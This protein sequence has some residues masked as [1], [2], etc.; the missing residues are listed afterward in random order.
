MKK[1]YSLLVVLCLGLVPIQGQ[2]VDLDRMLGTSAED[3]QRIDDAIAVSDAVRKAGN[4]I[5][6]ISDLFTDGKV[7]LPVG[8]K[9]SSDSPYEL[10]IRKIAQD[11]KTEKMVISATCA[12][13]FKDTGDPIAFEGE[14]VIE[15]NNGLGT[16]GKLSLITPVRRNIGKQSTLV[17]REGTSVSFNCEGIEEFDAKMTWVVT[18]DK[19]IPVDA[20]GNPTN[21][22]LQVPFEMQFSNFDSYVVSL[23][24]NQSFAIKSL[25]QF[26]N[27]TNG[28]FTVD[29]EL[30]EAGD[31]QI[32]LYEVASGMC[33][34]RR[35]ETGSD[36]YHLSY[37]LPHLSKGVY[38]L[39]VTVGSERRQVGM[40][41]ES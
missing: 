18:S 26:P 36:S 22:Q 1:I 4:Y 10:I 30:T 2:D 38:V 31:A 41:V 34:D 23:G 24:I 11:E 14:A 15:G 35:N 13:R 39:I 40:I 29:L 3:R 20:Q 16:N 12:F 37:N 19:I 28:V 33:V 5:S 8:V 7:T 9:P 27:P 32:L 6:S 25:S 21:K 17:V